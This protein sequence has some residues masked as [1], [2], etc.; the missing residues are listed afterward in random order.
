MKNYE[1]RGFSFNFNQI[2]F[3]NLYYLNVEQI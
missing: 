1:I 3:Y 2:R